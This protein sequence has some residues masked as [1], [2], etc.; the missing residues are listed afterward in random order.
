MSFTS[1]M[2]KAQDSIVYLWAETFENMTNLSMSRD[3]LLNRWQFHQTNYKENS[4]AIVD[5]GGSHGKVW[6]SVYHE[7]MAAAYGDDGFA[8]DIPIGGEYNEVWFE[9][10]LYA[11]PDFISVSKTGKFS[12][13]M[14]FGLSGGNDVLSP[15]GTWQLDSTING[16]GW[17]AQGVWGSGD[18]LRPY[19]YDQ[20]A[21]GQTHQMN[22]NL[23]IPKGYWIHIT[24]RVKMNTPGKKDGIFELYINDSLRA[25][26]TD[27]EWRSF[28]QG[29]NYG[30][31][32]DLHLCYFFGGGGAEF[33]SQ[34]DNFIRIDN[35][36]AYYYTPDSKSYLP[37]PAK[38]GQKIPRNIPTKNIYAKKILFNE[39]RH[40]PTGVIKS[41]YNVGS[42]PPT[43][44]EVIK[45]EIIRP[46]GPIKI[47]ITKFEP[48]IDNWPTLNAYVKIY[49][50][51]GNN[52]TLLYT[53]NESN[54]PSGTYTVN[55]NEATIEYFSG[56][57]FNRGFALNYSSPVTPGDTNLV[58]E[59]PVPT[60]PGELI[61]PV[62]PIEPV[63]PVE[64]VDTITTTPPIT[65]TGNNTI[66]VNF[67][68]DED[69]VASS[70]W[71]NL[72]ARANGTTHHLK[73]ESGESTDVDLYVNSSDIYG[74]IGGSY[75][76]IY[77]DG[78]IRTSWRADNHT[79]KSIQ[80]RNLIAGKKYKIE[81]F[82]SNQGEIVGN[83]P[84]GTYLNNYFVNNIKKS[85]SVYQNTN[86]ILTW[87]VQPS[88]TS[89]DISWN[90]ASGYYG[91]I[92]CLILSDAS[93][94][95][96]VDQP[97]ILTNNNP[98]INNQ[99][100]TVNETSYD[101]PVM[102]T[103]VASDPD[104]GQT[105]A[106][107]IVSGNEDNLFAINSGTGSVSTLNDQ[108][109]SY[110]KLDYNLVI[111]VTD[112]GETPK[113]SQATLTLHLVPDT[114]VVYIDPT[115]RNDLS[116]NGTIEHP[117]NSWSDVTWKN[118]YKYYQKRGT[119]ASEDKISIYCNGATLGAYGDGEKPK[120]ISTAKD[121]AIQALDKQLVNIVNLHII[122]ENAISSIYLLGDQNSIYSIQNCII[123]SS[124]YA[125]RVV[126][127]KSISL[128]YNTIKNCMRGLYSF[129]N[130]NIIY[131]NIF[132]NNNNAVEIASLN[133]TTEVYNNVFYENGSGVSSSHGDLTLY[134]NIFYLVKEGDIALNLKLDA[135]LSDNNIFYPERN[136]F[137]S[138]SDKTYNSLK[139][140]SSENQIDL[141]SFCKD[142][143]FVDIYN[144]DFNLSE[145]S[146]AINTGKLLGI[147]KDYFGMPVPY[148][149]LA[150]I[151]ASEASFN[152][153]TSVFNSDFES[154][155][156]VYPNPS[157]GRFSIRLKNEEFMQQDASISVIDFTG[158]TVYTQIIN[159]DENQF[160]ESVDLSGYKNG[161]YYVMY[162]SA[163]KSITEK[164]LLLK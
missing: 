42:F 81:I 95:A 14:L 98:V 76:G 96:V 153:M 124:D 162:Q 101:A 36:I 109:F 125:V 110:T 47:D 83:D 78:A 66:K 52:K 143:L 68:R 51:T 37:G 160:F 114:K 60:D 72:S 69:L 93:E 102:G 137:I 57:C 94:D 17:E 133:S 11:D 79:T 156:T 150:D 19:Y 6:Q 9:S 132:N 119:T 129:A 34:R 25:Q 138:F 84:T 89:L 13:K 43:S 85:I 155:L 16:N 59:E 100:F 131:Y 35:M 7:G 106:Y 29:E 44:F 136:G 130:E 53:F 147:D 64:P 21:D 152:K 154:G 31:V 56:L 90:G 18:A 61:V 32:S 105:L 1:F 28:Q 158:K 120:I 126:E 151:G 10:D 135:L 128:K 144:E 15:S 12:G 8:I 55:S 80:L 97:I 58:A 159:S 148:A 115:N 103:V 113:S 117:Y 91:F 139:Q 40:N 2:L 5:I 122:A 86:N 70:D 74:S 73:N 67:V 22:A 161:V 88:G 54:Y 27:V 38:P 149:N 77:A 20:I 63:E 111:K 41:H 46:T 134:N 49:S 121:Y 71:N 65:P 112:N 141:N 24:R 146:P 82:G 4:Q 116:E 157:N 23:T 127:G 163:V 142:P 140:F 30:K 48:G 108:I 107:S 99:S 50:G 3:S 26:A 118:D 33:A 39:V 123:E 62:E 92:N 104:A 45:K 145:A 164:L 87:I 75:P